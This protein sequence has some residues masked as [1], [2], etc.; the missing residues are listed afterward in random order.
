MLVISSPTSGS[1]ILRHVAP[2]LLA[3]AA[4]VLLSLTGCLMPFF[5]NILYNLG[6]GPIRLYD[7]HVL[8]LQHWPVAPFWILILVTFISILA[9]LY[10]LPHLF[11]QCRKTAT[12]K[13]SPAVALAGL[14]AVFYLLPLALA[15]MFDRYLLLPIPLLGAIVGA[16]SDS[17]D[18][19]RMAPILRSAAVL[20]LFVFLT[21]SFCATRDYFAW[22]RARWKA[23]SD[24]VDKQHIPWSKID[25][26]FEFNGL[27]GYHSDDSDRTA[28]DSCKGKSWWWVQDNEY[29]L[30]MGPIPGYAV[31]AEYEFRRTVPPGHGAI[32]VLHR[33]IADQP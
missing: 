17:P 28:S 31:K 3:L 23:V 14:C 33:K 13:H 6:L 4:T 24:L 2:I 18:Q 22:N 10:L 7:V 30:A 32:L 26:G 12:T 29:V 1:R 8:K 9:T 11:L 25:G 16:G 27:Y 15:G 5:G 21:F 20:V 19:R